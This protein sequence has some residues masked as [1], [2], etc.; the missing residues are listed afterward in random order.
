MTATSRYERNLVIYPLY[1]AVI[2]A[3]VMLPVIV[4][5]WEDNGLDLF[6]VFALQALYAVAVVVLEVPTGMVADRLGKRT[7]LLAG[8]WAMAIGYL[9]YAMGHGFWAFLAAE[10][11]LAIGSAL[12]SGADTSLLYD[13]LK[14]LGRED[15]YT[16]REGRARAV[17]LAAFAACNLL[18][19]V[20]GSYD[21]RAAI[22]ASAVGPAL[23]LLVAPWF[24]EVQQRTPSGSVAAAWRG[25]RELITQALRFVRKHALV[26]WQIG[27]L[28][29]LSGSAMWLLW[30]YQP[31]M[32]L[33]GW[34]VWSFGIAFAAFNL[35]AAFV[36]EKA[37]AVEERFGQRGTLLLLMGLQA[38]PPLLMGLFVHPFAVVL[39]FGQQSVRALA[40]PI[41]AD[42]LLR[43]TWADKRSTVLSIAALGG[44]LFF[45]ATAP[46]L[47]LL[48]ELDDLVVVLLVQGGL[49]VALFVVMWWLYGRIPAKYFRVK[50]SVEERQ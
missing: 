37:A 42:R 47:A 3:P 12:I 25:Y 41:I 11:V 19:G 10:V 43:Y 18:G 32:Q 49:L 27:L 29:I 26:R 20:I 8:T 7:S 31:Y 35:F 30:I 23:A 40:R 2:Y 38:V 45:A 14:A 6:D 4:L 22:W 15:E 24:V 33:T 46:A 44:R 9:A 5:F 21:Y 34:P 1:T 39:I 36:S 48:G 17:Q 16:R 50:A 13:T 28:A